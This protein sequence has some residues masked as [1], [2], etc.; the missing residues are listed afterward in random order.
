MSDGRAHEDAGGLRRAVVVF[1]KRPR[2]GRVKTRL[3][4][5]LR[6]CEAARLYGCLLRDT[7]DLV[8]EIPAL[9]R[10]A[11]TPWSEAAWFRRV[12]PDFRLLRQGPGGLGRRMAAVARAC[13][14]SGARSVVLLGSDSPTLP[15]S[16]IEAAFRRLEDG[17]DAVLG[18]CTDGGYYLVGLSGPDVS[19]FEGV[20]FSSPTTL[21][22]TLELGERSGLR[23]ETVEPWYDVDGPADLE[24]LRRELAEPSAAGP[25][26]RTSRF[27]REG[28]G[29]G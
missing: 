19:L 28:P 2:A 8:R 6:P 15:P 7:L 18:P 3:C 24:R 11:V 4:P 21:A 25:A 13:F 26:P 27:L 23:V 29:G 12:A 20:P 9:R 22:A 17:A 16:S 10:L 14:A 1:A 5:P